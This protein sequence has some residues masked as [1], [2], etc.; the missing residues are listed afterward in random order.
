MS[1]L[2]HTA[3]EM[4]EAV[5]SPQL[6]KQGDSCKDT[7]TVADLSPLHWFTEDE[8][9]G[10]R[11]QQRPWNVPPILFNI[12]ESTAGQ[13]RFLCGFSMETYKTF[14]WK[15]HEKKLCFK[16]HED[17]IVTKQFKGSGSWFFGTDTNIVPDYR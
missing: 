1:S 3:P 10:Q 4:F 11:V 5:A 7:A 13:G 16:K 12:W 15:I 14:Y 6:G 17:M 9:A 8:K 2:L